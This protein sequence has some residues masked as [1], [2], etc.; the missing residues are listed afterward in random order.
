MKK[1]KEMILLELIFPK[2]KKAKTHS[3]FKELFEQFSVQ[4]ETKQQQ[5]MPMEILQNFDISFE[6]INKGEDKRT[7]LILQNLPPNMTK[8]KLIVLLKDVGNFNFVYVHNDNKISRSLRFAFVNLINYRNVIQLFQKFNGL[9]L[10]EN[11]CKIP[12]RV[13]YSRIQGKQDL[14]ATFIKP[15]KTDLCK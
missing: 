9:I 15:K 5:L 13:Y 6:K 1:S 11:L 3:R 7:S 10:Q 2:F 14:T 12:I 8:E 4:E